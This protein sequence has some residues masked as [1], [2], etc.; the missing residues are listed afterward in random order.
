MELARN[1]RSI[2]RATFPVRIGSVLVIRGARVVLRP[3]RLEEYDQWLSAIFADA[4]DRS[5]FPAGPPDPH[6]LRDRVE[7]SG[8]MRESSLDLAIEADGRLVGGIGTY[9]EPGRRMWPGLFFLSIGLFDA[10]DR[11]RGLGTEAIRLLC[12]WLFRSAHAERIEGSTAVW[13]TAMRR[14]FEKLGFAFGGVKRRWDI[15]WAHYAISRKQWNLERS[16]R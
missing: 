7:H 10:E 12:D 5:L 14:V 15:D 16:R 3:F 6:R 8:E 2:L 11:G 1:S 13:N 4:E 9:A